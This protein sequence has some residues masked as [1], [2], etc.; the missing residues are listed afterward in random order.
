MITDYTLEI[1]EDMNFRHGT[2]I[3]ITVKSGNL[4]LEDHLSPIETVG[5]A[6]TVA[7]I[8][9]N[10][11]ALSGGND[12]WDPRTGRSIA[13]PKLFMRARPEDR[14]I[15]ELCSCEKCET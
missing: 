8:L 2:Q 7:C 13:R 11:A 9:Y 6:Y 10:R 5:G 4:I 15:N 14:L 12:W 3:R 1:T